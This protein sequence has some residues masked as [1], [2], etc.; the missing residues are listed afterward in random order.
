MNFWMM[1][2]KTLNNL[3]LEKEYP[4]LKITV[5]QTISEDVDI[6]ECPYCNGNQIDICK[7]VGDKF[8]VRCF[9]CHASGPMKSTQHETVNA[10]NKVAKPVYLSDA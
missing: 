2:P 7:A 1:L 4:M 10:W 6:Y 9:D 5:T 8:Y 3:K